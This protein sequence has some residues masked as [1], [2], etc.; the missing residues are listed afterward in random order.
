VA[1]VIKQDIFRLQIASECL[2]NGERRASKKPLPINNIQ[3]VKVL[4]SKQEFR[5]V[6]T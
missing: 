4:Q 3:F 1:C 6:E 5:A 2:N